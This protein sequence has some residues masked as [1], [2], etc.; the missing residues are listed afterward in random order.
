MRGPN[1]IHRLCRQ[2]HQRHER[3]QDA[4]SRKT[5]SVSDP[6]CATKRRVDIPAKELEKLGHRARP[7]THAINLVFRLGLVAGKRIFARNNKSTLRTWLDLKVS[8]RG[9]VR[10]VPHPFRLFCGK[11]GNHKSPHQNRCHPERSEGS[12]FAFALLSVIPEGNL[13]L[14]RSG[15]QPRHPRPSQNLYERPRWPRDLCP[16]TYP[17]RDGDSRCTAIPA[18]ACESATGPHIVLRANGRPRLSPEL[19]LQPQ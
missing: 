5:K 16:E 3:S 8:A 15:L 10:R 7:R 6:R 9:A 4:A 11:G 14:G 19:L 1:D 12:A 13:H 18:R 2:A 17:F